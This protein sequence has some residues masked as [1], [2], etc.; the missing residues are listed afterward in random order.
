MARVTS[1]DGDTVLF[2]LLAGIMQLG[3]TLAPYLFIIVLGYAL[4]TALDGKED[5]GFMLKPRRSSR[6][7][8]ITITDLDCADD[9]AIISNCVAN[10]QKIL[11]EIE[12]AAAQVGLYINT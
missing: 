5:L 7:P 1:P 6:H 8:A 9:L 12:N 10:A 2:K 4:R 11:T 3:D